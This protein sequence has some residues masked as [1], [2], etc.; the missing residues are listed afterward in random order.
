MRSL[1][2]PGFTRKNDIKRDAAEVGL[3]FIWLMI[4]SSLGRLKAK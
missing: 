4:G 2:G 1:G 3:G